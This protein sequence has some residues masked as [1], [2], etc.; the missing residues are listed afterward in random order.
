MIKGRGLSP[1][2]ANASAVVCDQYISPLGE[3]RGDGY[4]ASGPCEGSEISG[5]I[6]IFKGGRGSTVGSYIFLQLRENGRAP[7]GII[8]EKGEQ[9]IVTGAI[10]SDIPMVDSLPLDIFRTG[11]FVKIDGTTGYVEIQNVEERQVATA[12][13]IHEGRLLVMKR[14]DS[15][16]TYPGAIGGVSGYVEK[17]EGPA[18][19]AIREVREETSLRD[20]NVVKVGTEIQVRYGGIVFRI[21]PVLVSTSSADIK[22]N[23]ENS[24]FSW[25]TREELERMETVPKFKETYDLLISGKP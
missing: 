15:A 7:A 8:N 20:A 11:D 5:R 18:E 25:V 24:S 19:A 17:G 14:S 9:M 16:P 10:I 2:V 21:T 6:M 12:Y 22:L 3:I 4:I 1:G 13:V 23:Y